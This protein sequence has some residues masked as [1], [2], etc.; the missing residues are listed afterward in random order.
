VRSFIS[1]GSFDIGLRVYEVHVKKANGTEQL[2]EFD[3][4]TN[5]SVSEQLGGGLDD[6]SWP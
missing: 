5:H 2:F 1:K 4:N 6:T 3:L